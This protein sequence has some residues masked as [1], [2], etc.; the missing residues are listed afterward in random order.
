MD[1]GGVSEPGEVG[2]DVSAV[3][4]AASCCSLRGVAICSSVSSPGH[5]PS[6]AARPP[7]VVA[8]P[9]EGRQCWRKHS[10]ANQM[11]QPRPSIDPAGG[12]LAVG[13]LAV[14]GIMGLLDT[15]RGLRGTATIPSPT[16]SGGHGGQKPCVSRKFSRA[17][18]KIALFSGVTI[19]SLANASR[20]AA[21]SVEM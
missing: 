14:G 10:R 19:W 16:A 12:G 8:M 3:S 4:Q 21:K 17:L 18:R 7:P 1:S 9:G 2:A 20:A 5:W 11:Y 15:V 13:G 6:I